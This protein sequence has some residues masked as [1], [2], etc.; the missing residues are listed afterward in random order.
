MHVLVDRFTRR[1]LPAV[2]TAVGVALIAGGLLTYTN[3]TDRQRFL[4]G[5][6]SQELVRLRRRTLRQ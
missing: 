3:A 6:R 4:P 2:I 1:V 5:S